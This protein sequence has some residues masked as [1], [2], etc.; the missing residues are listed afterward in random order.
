LGL[1]ISRQLAAMMGGDIGLESEPGKGSSVWFTARIEK[2]PAAVEPVSSQTHNLSGLRVLIVDDNA[3]NRLILHHQM[4]AWGIRNDGATNGSEALEILQRAAEVGDPYALA[5][6]DMQMPGMDGLELARAIKAVPSIS[7][8]RLILL[9]SLGQQLDAEALRTT[10]IA[11]CMAKPVRASRLHDCVVTVVAGISAQVIC[12]PNATLPSAASFASPPPPETHTARILVAEDNSINQKVTLGMLHRLGYGADAV[13]DGQEALNALQRRRYDVIL[14][15]CQMPGLDGYETTRTI[16]RHEQERH[17]GAESKPA[18]H[19]IAMTANAMQGD[20]EKCLAAGMNDYVSKPVRT[21]ELRAAFERW[22]AGVS[23][24]IAHQTGSDAS[25]IMGEPET[26]AA[27]SPPVDMERLQEVASGDPEQTGII[28]RLYLDQAHQL[29]GNLDSAI[30]SG[31]AR[32]VAHFA[33]KCGG[34]S[35]TCGM[36]AVVAPLCELERM[37]REGRLNGAEQLSAQLNRQLGLVEGFL[38]AHLSMASF[39]PARS[40]L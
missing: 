5:I 31:S 4:L 22:K 9:T 2:Q 37:G 27:S 20:R 7:G 18:I 28:A 23:D 39:H 17:Q 29:I 40:A 1:A 34:A 19:I 36:T 11:A 26:G 32:D 14:M 15:D 25:V 13:G 30:K 21:P 12:T 10:G 33:H 35:S 24:Q 16:R 8:V 3:A 38:A 6:L